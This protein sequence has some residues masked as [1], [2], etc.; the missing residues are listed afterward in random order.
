MGVTQLLLLLFQSCLTLCDP[1]NFCMPGSSD[2]HH[3]PEFAQ[4]HVHWANWWCYL[5]H[6][7]PPLCLQ[8]FQHWSLFQ[9]VDSSHQVAKVLELRLQQ[10]PIQG[11]S[12]LGLTGLI[13]FCPRKSQESFTTPQFESIS[14]SALSLL[15]GSTLTSIHY[16][17]KNHSFDYVGLCWQSVWF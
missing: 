11:W 15:Y 6:L 12:S 2:L 14:S 13:A 3:Y 17:W 4:I 16:Y 5:S 8:S 9:W 10:P 7:L 1:M